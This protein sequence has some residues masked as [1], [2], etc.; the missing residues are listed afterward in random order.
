MFKPFLLSFCVT[1]LFG[2][3]FSQSAQSQLP[4]QKLSD[5]PSPTEELPHVPVIPPN[6]VKLQGDLT[7]LLGQPLQLAQVTLRPNAVPQM[8]SSAQ[9]ELSE[10]SLVQPLPIRVLV[11]SDS[12]SLAV[13]ID[14]DAPILNTDGETVAVLPQGIEYTV[15]PNSEGITIGDRQFPALVQI[16]SNANGFAYVDGH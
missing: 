3:A 5:R 16:A 7:Q 2:L 10:S 8:Q 12:T 9:P 13:A 14:A 6:L 11:A 1:G 15:Q 4:P